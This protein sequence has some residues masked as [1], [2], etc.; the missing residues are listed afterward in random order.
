MEFEY[1]IAS[2]RGSSFLALGRDG[3]ERVVTIAPSFT[4]PAVGDYITINADDRIVALA[5][6]RGV[7]ARARA[8]RG[9]AAQIVATHLDVMFI[10]TSPGREFSPSRVERYLTA[11]HAGGITSV[12][13]LNKRDI[14]S[15]L[16]ALRMEL[17]LVA[18]DAP[19]YA[20]SASTSD[21]CDALGAYLGH[22][23]TVAVVGSSGVGKSTLANRL[24]GDER[25]ATG[26]TRLA[27]GRGKHTTT[28]REMI[29]LSSGA[30][31]ID[32]PGMRAFAP[33]ADEDALG[34]VFSDIDEAAAR[35]RFG[36]CA[37]GG[38]PGC[39]VAAEIDERRLARWRALRVE[40]AY[41]E[42]RDNPAL[43]AAEKKR[44]RQRTKAQRAVY[45]K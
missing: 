34:E 11:A 39:A 40:L 28:S 35:C 45:R 14:A 43:I 36:D 37:H 3:S 33:W 41:L 21:G 31:L 15:D 12:I 10:V 42:R 6:R 22:G 30:W 9:N 8:D 44:W 27:D 2:D 19:V 32:T 20:I 17:A 16:P 18:G 4:R 1:R 26:A 24:I 38:E 13:V 25:F 5:A 23:S 7:L 29:A